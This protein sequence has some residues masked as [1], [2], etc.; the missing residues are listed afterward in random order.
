MCVHTVCLTTR[1]VC[2]LL[3]LELSVSVFLDRWWSCLLLQAS[4][5]MPCVDHPWVRCLTA[6]PPPWL[7]WP[8][9]RCSVDT[10]GQWLLYWMVQLEKVVVESSVQHCFIKDRL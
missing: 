4:Q 5:H 7:R 6:L 2:A 3:V 8:H 9:F 1:H 10:H